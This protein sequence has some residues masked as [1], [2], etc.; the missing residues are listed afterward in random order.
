VNYSDYRHLLF[1]KKPTGV[2]LVTINRPEAM[3]AT[4]ARLH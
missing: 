4:N 2:V 1:E 3:N